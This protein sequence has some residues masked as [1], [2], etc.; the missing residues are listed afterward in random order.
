[1]PDMIAQS[2]AHL[3]PPERQP[4]E[5]VSTGGSSGRIHGRGGGVNA[6]KSYERRRHHR[7]LEE[8]DET[9]IYRHDEADEEFFKG[10][11]R[12]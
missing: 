10:W 6:T 5:G 3:R 11:N 8:S 9:E 7:A 12:K 2:L 4:L 1:M